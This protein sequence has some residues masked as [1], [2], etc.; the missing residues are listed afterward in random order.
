MTNQTNLITETDVQE[1]L[2]INRTKYQK[3]LATLE[4]TFQALFDTYE[5]QDR[6]YRIYS[7]ADKQRGEFFKEAWKIC[8]KVNSERKKPK[9]VAYQIWNVRDIIGMTIV[10]VYPKD[11]K[12][13]RKIIDEEIASGN[14]ECLLFTKQRG[15]MTPGERKS[16]EGYHAYHYHLGIPRPKFGRAACELQIKTVIHDA[17]GAKTHELSYKPKDQLVPELRQLINTI[18]DQLAQI[19]KQSDKI[20]SLAS[21]RTKIQDKKF[22]LAK[23][24]LLATTPKSNIDKKTFFGIKDGI[25]GN[26]ELYG[27]LNK[28]SSEIQAVLGQIDDLVGE[29]RQNRDSCR[30]YCLLAS[31]TN[32]KEVVEIASDRLNHWF[33]EESTPM[34][35]FAAL[36]AMATAHFS[37]GHGID[38]VRIAERALR[39]Y[40]PRLNE[41][42]DNS[43]KIGGIKDKLFLCKSNLAY[44]YSEI[45]ES[46]AGK[47]LEARDQARILISESRELI[48]ELGIP[49]NESD[50]EFVLENKFRDTEGIV[51]IAS[52]KNVDEADEGLE[53]CKEVSRFAQQRKFQFKEFGRA[54]KKLRKLFLDVNELRHTWK[55][56]DLAG[57]T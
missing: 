24:Q 39:E 14:L 11:I 34:G 50:E 15:Q 18:G 21:M 5:G 38:A 25:L 32:D 41:I 20:R 48:E 13:V 19:D 31:I 42:K 26:Q 2:T 37:F 54:Y 51:L 40:A 6:I 33:L 55:K 1:F 53:I 17:W 7:R 43:T 16:S 35:K 30:L 29:G 36:N 8:F 9:P 49:R 27:K 46:D 12:F 28:T 44:F 47:K 23:I 10:V 57:Q 56:A 3:L 4:D 52:A 45:C 22:K